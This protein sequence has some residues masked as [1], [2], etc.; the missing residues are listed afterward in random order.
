M[1]RKQTRR[2]SKKRVKGGGFFDPK[3]TTPVDTSAPTPVVDTSSTQ[4]PNA[5][6]SKPWW[7]IWGGRT[8]HRRK[9]RNK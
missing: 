1:G 7:K 6:P 4:P 8:R 5:T 3:I 9:N 2:R